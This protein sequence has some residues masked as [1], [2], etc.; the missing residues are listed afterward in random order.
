MKK[1]ISIT[2]VACLFS[3]L[4][5]SRLSASFDIV[6][7]SDFFTEIGNNLSEIFS[8]DKCWEKSVRHTLYPGIFIN[9]HKYLQKELPGALGI[10]LYESDIEAKTIYFFSKYI[11]RKAFVTA[12]P[13]RINRQF[14]DKM[15]FYY[16]DGRVDYFARSCNGR[17][18]LLMLYPGYPAYSVDDNM[19]VTHFMDPFA[20]ISTMPELRKYYDIYRPAE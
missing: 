18:K 1:F 10:E 19:V 11:T 14:K 15:F 6:K 20:P 3:L 16:E 13:K 17:W 8:S 2:R 12:L 7:N 4:L 9:L 5:C